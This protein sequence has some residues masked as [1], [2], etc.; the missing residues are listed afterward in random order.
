MAE[1]AG[2]VLVISHDRYFLDRVI[3]KVVE[4]EDG[5]AFIYHTNYSG[6]QKEK[7][8]RLLL[9]FAQYQEQQKKIKK[10]QESIKQLIEWGNQSNPPNPGFHRRAASM[11][12]AL[13]RMV[14]LKRP[15]LERKK[16]GLELRQEDRSGKQVVYFD[17]VGKAFGERFLFRHA[18]GLLRYGET[19]MLL[20]ANGCG[21]STL[22][23]MLMGREEVTEGS[24]AL[25]SRVVIG[26][27][28]QQEHPDDNRQTV[29]QFFREQAGVEE[30][31]ARGKLARFLFY[32]PDVF[33]SVSN[34]SGGEWTRLRFAVLM[35]LKPNL[36]I[37]DEPTNHLD[38]DSREVLEEALEEFPGTIL[39]VSHDRYFIDLACRHDLEPGG[40]RAARHPWG[41]G[42]IPAAGGF[43]K[44]GDRARNRSR[45]CP[46][47]REAARIPSA[48]AAA[49]PGRGNPSRRA[50]AAAPRFANDGRRGRLRRDPAGGASRTTRTAG[51]TSSPAVRGMA[52]S[53]RIK[54]S[55]RTASF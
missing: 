34:L 47:S 42:G 15:V 29:L 11:Q 17:R 50:G 33:K 24:I 30:G 10:M 49:K 54:R 21:K 22:L 51:G 46:G 52:A 9:Q 26:Y 37:L 32:G 44:A 53:F 41:A 18:N 35:E 7:E 13:D 12:K 20:G 39:A 19:V 5:E 55:P 2:T 43:G 16:M 3:T 25:G 27:L 14:K 6:Y 38:I 23:H 1:Y 28:A 48:C 36:L 40:K 8:E 31:E 45:S 4:I